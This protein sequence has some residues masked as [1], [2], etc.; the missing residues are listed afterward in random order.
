M[1]IEHLKSLALDILS[2]KKRQ[3]A[4][5]ASIVHPFQLSC[6]IKPL[7]EMCIP[8]SFTTERLDRCVHL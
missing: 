2:F 4:L 6:C 5:D 1:D 3:L 7:T 8:S